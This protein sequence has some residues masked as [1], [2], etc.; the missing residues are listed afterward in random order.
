MKISEKKTNIVSNNTTKTKLSVAI[1]CLIGLALLS[2]PFIINYFLVYFHKQELGNNLLFIIINNVLPA[3]ATIAFFSG[4]WEAHSKRAFAKE[5]LEL[6]GIS[7]NYIESGIQNVY[8]E[9]TDINWNELLLNTKNAVFFFTYA[10]SWRSNNRT[11]LKAAHEQGTKITVILP[12][13]KSKTITDALD[14]DFHYGAYAFEGS[15][16]KNKSSA[17]LIKDAAE[18][19]LKLNATVMIYHGNIKTTYYLM[20]DKCIYAPFKHSKEKSSVPSI[21]CCENGSFFEFCKR[22]IKSIIAQ[23][24]LLGELK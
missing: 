8:K 7:N 10:Y 21:L 24:E 19:F 16:D 11:A 13:Y 2:L 1:W 20:D 18:F 23:S 9:F 15:E 6:A 17:Q 12:D 3:L 5:V 22:D 4:A 14:M